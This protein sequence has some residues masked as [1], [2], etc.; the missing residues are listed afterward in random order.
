MLFYELNFS[1]KTKITEILKG[2]ERGDE[3]SGSG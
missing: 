3:E 2:H 1:I